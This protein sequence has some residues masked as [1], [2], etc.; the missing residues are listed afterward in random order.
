ML[1]ELEILV[2]GSAKDEYLLQI[3]LKE[4][5]GLLARPRGRALLLRD[6][7]AQ[8]RS[9]VRR[10]QLPRP[11]REHRA[12]AAARRVQNARSDGGGRGPRQ[13]PHGAARR[14]RAPAPRGVPHARRLRRPVHHPLSRRAGRTRRRSRPPGTAGRSRRRPT[15]SRARWRAATTGRRSVPRRGGPPLD[16][17]VPLLFNADVVISVVAPRRG[18]PGLFR[19]RRRRRALLRRRGRRRAALARWA[20]S[21]SA[22]ATTCSSPR[23]WCTAS[24]PTIGP[25]VWLSIECAAGFGL[26]RAVAQRGRPAAHGR[27]LQPPRLPPARVR[28]AARRRPARSGD[29]ARRRLSRLPL[30]PTRRWTS[31]AGTAR[32]TRGRSRSSTSSRASAWSTCR[33]RC[34]ARSRRAAR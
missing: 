32:S 29:Q 9:G 1:R 18:R 15:T 16:A 22:R 3:F 5:A 6:H 25:Q 26:P 21:R 14:R 28:G 33:R 17:R 31:S 7:P 10:R 23:A 30:S 34:T 13:T 4:A 8:G 2:D 27:A 12:R 24:C 20:T 11:V 19:Q